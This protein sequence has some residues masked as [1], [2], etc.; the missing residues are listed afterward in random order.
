MNSGFFNK[1]ENNV[2]FQYLITFFDIYYRNYISNFIYVLRK[3]TQR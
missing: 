1:Y 2:D 3:I